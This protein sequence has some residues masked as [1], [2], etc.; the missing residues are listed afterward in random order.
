MSVIGFEVGP[1]SKFWG[2]FVSWLGL[3]F[4]ASWTVFNTQQAWG[5]R[6]LQC[7]ST[8]KFIVCGSHN[9]FPFLFEHQLLKSCDLC[10]DLRSFLPVSCRNVRKT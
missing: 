3:I 8:G 4:A 1:K 10:L 6:A 7:F 5:L 2:L 9:V